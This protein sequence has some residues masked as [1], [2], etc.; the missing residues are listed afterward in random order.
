MAST[1][2]V[3]GP[4]GS[5]GA[6]M[7]IA[8]YGADGLGIE[9]SLAVPPAMVEGE[10]DEWI[11]NVFCEHDGGP[12]ATDFLRVV[13]PLGAFSAEALPELSRAVR[14]AGDLGLR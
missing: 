4:A 1:A 10:P 9:V 2:S 8:P 7:S 3:A 5:F 14:H 6:V 11:V 13:S 12:P